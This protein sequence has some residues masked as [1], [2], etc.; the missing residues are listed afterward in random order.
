MTAILLYSAQVLPNI[1]AGL[2][3]PI[4]LVC[5]VRDPVIHILDFYQEH[6]V[7]ENDYLANLAFAGFLKK[8]NV[9]GQMITI[10][11]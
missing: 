2:R 1:A 6:Y 4:G 5:G 8:D 3:G 9:I 10:L 11:V 7:S